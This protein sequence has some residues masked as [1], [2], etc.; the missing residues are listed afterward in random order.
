HHIV[1]DGASVR[2]LV[3]DLLAAYA[4]AELPAP[5]LTYVDYTRW[6]LDRSDAVNEHLPYW[7]R[8]LADLPVLDLPTDRPRPPVRTTAGAGYRSELPG[9]VVRGLERLGQDHGATLFMTL[10]AAVQVLLS[11]YAGQGDVAVGTIT[12]GRSHPD[13]DDLLGFFVN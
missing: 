1:T 12:A 4:G 10:V 3:D 11:R 13:L 2:L 6:A 5:A 9:E 7:R 8:T